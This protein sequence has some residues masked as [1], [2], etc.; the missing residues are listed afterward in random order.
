MAFIITFAGKLVHNS[1]DSKQTYQHARTV[2]SN[3]NAHV[4]QTHIYQSHTQHIQYILRTRHNFYNNM[5]YQ[6]HTSVST[7]RVHP[8]EFFKYINVNHSCKS[9]TQVRFS[10]QT[11][12]RPI[13][14]H[15]TTF[16]TI[17]LWTV[18]KWTTI[19]F[20]ANFIQWENILYKESNTMSLVK[21]K[22]LRGKKV[23]TC[24]RRGDSGFPYSK[25]LLL[26]ESMNTILSIQYLN[27]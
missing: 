21:L 17:K 16:L 18:T 27:V 2:H 7:I 1:R 25:L 23:G 12:L 15:Y 13:Y 11:H 10:H 8:C 22:I 26:Q 6:S 19:F 14:N 9:F 24:A 3:H 20:G 4:W 5:P